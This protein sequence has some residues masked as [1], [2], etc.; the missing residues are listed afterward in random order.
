MKALDAGLLRP[1]GGGAPPALGVVEFG[2]EGGVGAELFMAAAVDG[3]IDNG[4]D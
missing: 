4:E 1:R 2:P 3:E